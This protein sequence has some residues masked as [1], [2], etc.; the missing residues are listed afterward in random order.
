[1]LVKMPDSASEK[2]PEKKLVLLLLLDLDELEPIRVSY[3]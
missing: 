2:A 1:V 3:V